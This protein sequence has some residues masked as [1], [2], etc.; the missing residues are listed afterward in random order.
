MFI[1]TLYKYV[2]IILFSQFFL[3]YIWLLYSLFAY[4]FI[5][6]DFMKNIWKTLFYFINK[7]QITALKNP[8]Y[9]GM[10]TE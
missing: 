8:G 6:Y 9:I 4:Y 2:K 3:L 10:K 1:R 5:F 7:Q